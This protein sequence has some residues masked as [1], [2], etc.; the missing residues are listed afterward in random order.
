MFRHFLAGTTL[1]ARSAAFYRAFLARSLMA[2]GATKL[3]VIH[4]SG[5]ATYHRAVVNRPC[6]P[7]A[8]YWLCCARWHVRWEDLAYG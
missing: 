4:L 6:V 5:A 8:G 3:A 1:P 2:E 7:S